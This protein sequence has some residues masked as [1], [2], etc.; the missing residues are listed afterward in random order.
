MHTGPSQPV[1][2]G[3]YKAMLQP[4]EI[5]IIFPLRLG[6]LQRR[7]E[8]FLKRERHRVSDHL[9]ILPCITQST[10]CKTTCS[11]HAHRFSVHGKKTCRY[12]QNFQKRHF[13]HISVSELYENTRTPVFCVHAFLFSAFIYSL[14]T[15]SYHVMF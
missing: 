4:N 15:L 1:R 8:V 10:S 5:Q 6:R 2:C 14:F 12:F 11:N 13:V 7:R 3:L 9:V